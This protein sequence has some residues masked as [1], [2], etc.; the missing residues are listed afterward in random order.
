[1]KYLMLVFFFTLTASLFSESYI[2]DWKINTIGSGNK[3]TISQ[4]ENEISIFRIIKQ[5]FE[6]EEYILYHLM[7]GNLND[8][9][10]KLYVK[11]DKLDKFEYLRDVSF[12]KNDINTLKIDDKIYTRVKTL[13]KQALASNE[14]K[15]NKIE[16]IY[17]KKKPSD[18][19][20][21]TSRKYK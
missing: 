6:G 8:D 16:I 5:N 9:K 21:I 17:L 15:D 7:K 11:E 2:G 18:K 20:E 10:L 12:K 13:K 3:A 19:K 4:T 14:N 1:M